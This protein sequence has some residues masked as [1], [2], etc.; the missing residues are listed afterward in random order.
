M[1]TTLQVQPISYCIGSMECSAYSI[2][3]NP[4]LILF[5][6]LLKW[7]WL[8]W[9]VIVYLVGIWAKKLSEL[10]SPWLLSPR[11]TSSGSFRCVKS[12]ISKLVREADN[13]P[14]HEWVC[15]PQK[16]SHSS[17][18]CV[19]VCVSGLLSIFSKRI[20]EFW[21]KENFLEYFKHIQRRNSTMNSNIAIIQFQQWS[22]H[23]LSYSMFTLIRYLPLTLP[24]LFWSK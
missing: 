13:L 14:L 8:V 24:P 3:C 12:F 4:A 15:E 22:T 19:C 1:D 5:F 20:L 21:K 23:S 17:W 10:G 6:L 7:G 16:I 9:A 18:I 11:V 2:L